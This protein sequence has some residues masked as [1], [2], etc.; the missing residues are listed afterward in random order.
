MNKHRAIEVSIVVVV[1]LILL[2]LIPTRSDTI[3]VDPVTGSVKRQASWQ[4][5]RRPPIVETSAIERWIV[6]R[7]GSHVPTWRFVSRST[8]TIFGRPLSIACGEAPMYLLRAG[9]LND[10]FVLN[11]TN[12][13][14]VKFINLMR[15]GSAEERRESVQAAYRSVRGE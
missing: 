1:V 4:V 8:R 10:R 15:T 5:C 6:R 12:E 3:W 14:I 11:S 7:E 2:A 9:D 13:Q